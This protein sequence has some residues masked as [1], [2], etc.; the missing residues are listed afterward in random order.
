MKSGHSINLN[1]PAFAAVL[2][3]AGSLVAAPVAKADIDFEC[4][5]GCWGAAAA[6]PSTGQEVM[7]LGCVQQ[8]GVRTGP[9][10][11]GRRVV[12]E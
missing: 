4:K 3:A 6:S 7:R 10:R 5:P 1:K 8:S 9:D 2:V 11:E 12:A